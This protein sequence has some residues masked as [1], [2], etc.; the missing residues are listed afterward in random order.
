[1]F[2]PIWIIVVIVLGLLFF[3]DSGR[4]LLYLAGW[5]ALISVVLVGG[6][7]LMVSA[8]SD[9]SGPA[10]WILGVLSVAV[11]IYEL[12]QKRQRGEKQDGE[13]T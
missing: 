5:L 7:G 6:C 8:R 4:D 9:P 3:T 2:I 11:V 1:M 10:V 12:W 13:N